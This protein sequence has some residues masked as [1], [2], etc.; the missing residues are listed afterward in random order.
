MPENH[1]ARA[2]INPNGRCSSLTNEYL[3]NRKT[4]KRVHRRWSGREPPILKLAKNAV[5]WEQE[6]RFRESRGEKGS[7]YLGMC[8]L[9]VFIGEP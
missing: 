3:Q 9:W 4:S 6:R 7:Q 1:W 5:I 2:L 8:N